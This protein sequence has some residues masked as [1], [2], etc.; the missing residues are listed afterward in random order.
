M[1]HDKNNVFRIS[2]LQNCSQVCHQQGL[3]KGQHEDDLRP[4]VV[5]VVHWLPTASQ[6]Q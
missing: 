1:S 5:Q 6:L 4:S 3:Q 2:P